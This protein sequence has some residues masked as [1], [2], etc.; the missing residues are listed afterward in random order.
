MLCL[1]SQVSP[2]LL[3]QGLHHAPLTLRP[4]IVDP[5]EALSLSLETEIKLDLSS[6]TMTPKAPD[7][8]SQS[9]GHCRL[10]PGQ[11]RVGGVTLLTPPTITPGLRLPREG[12]KGTTLTILGSSALYTL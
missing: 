4:A 5:T 7:S 11:E 1:E 2:S 3:S 9:P 6:R 8:I 12:K 10:S